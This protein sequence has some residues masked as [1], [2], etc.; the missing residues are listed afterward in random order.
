MGA[1]DQ[2]KKENQSS[3]ESEKKKTYSSYDLRNLKKD[4]AFRIGMHFVS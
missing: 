3:T 4:F 2:D 1:D